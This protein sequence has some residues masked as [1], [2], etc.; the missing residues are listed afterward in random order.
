M[1]IKSKIIFIILVFSIIFGACKKTTKSE[2][3]EK[4]S[5]YYEKGILIYSVTSI[6]DRTVE[7]YI[8]EHGDFDYPV[9]IILRNYKPGDQEFSGKVKFLNIGLKDIINNLQP[10]SFS[11]EDVDEL[12]PIEFVVFYNLEIENIIM[13]GRFYFGS[14]LMDTGTQSFEAEIK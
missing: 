11:I 8:S 9:E 5:I 14:P 6:A 13:E 12:F 3:E 1:E 4:D 2:N 7:D 10:D